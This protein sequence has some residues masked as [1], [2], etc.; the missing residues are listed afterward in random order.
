MKK[1]IS[2][3]I[4]LIILLS[5]SIVSYAAQSAVV[6]GKEIE[7]EYGEESI[8]PVSIE[9]NTGMMGFKIMLDYDSSIISVKNVSAGALTGAGNFAHNAGLKNGHVDIIW[10]GTSNVS[11]AGTLFLIDLA[12]VGKISKN[13]EIKL[14]YSQQDTFNEEYKDVTLD[15]KN[16]VIKPNGNSS[17][18]P[19]IDSD[20][21]STLPIDSAQIVDIVEVVLSKTGN[22]NLSNIKNEKEFIKEFNNMLESYMGTDIYNVSSIDEIKD[23][24]NDAYK[25]VIIN[26]I[27]SKI[28]SETIKDV[29]D[30]ALAELG[31]NSIDQLNDKQKKEFINL[32]EQELKDTDRSIPNLSDI[33]TDSSIDAVQS[34][35]NDAQTSE[36][37]KQENDKNNTE[38]VADQKNQSNNKPIVIAVSIVGMIAVLG[39]ITFAFLKQKNKKE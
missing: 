17:E 23:L 22:E 8:I 18:T 24:H 13:A 19:I 5:C 4:S 20:E 11:G 32:V 21:G 31:V 29:V 39:I 6:E 34:V 37:N 16:I 3:I 15:C 26:D 38:S 2:F 28:D 27:N 10:N 36:D 7:L 14:S 9:N 30:N 1:T 35:Y 12:V 25:D 33:D